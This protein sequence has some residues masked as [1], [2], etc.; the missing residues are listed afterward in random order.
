MHT[1]HL[2]SVR[3]GVVGTA[4]LIAV[5]LAS[6]IILALLALNIVDPDSTTAT[7]ASI[8]AIAIGFYAGGMFAG[9]RARAAPILHGIVI[10]LVS[11]IV[12]FLLNA[13]AAFLAPD[14]GWSALTPNLAVA[15]V[16]MQMAA[17]VLGARMGYRQTTKGAA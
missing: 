15:L 3:P 1:E 4:W 17:A 11:L 13:I 12:W 5:G 16:L 6:L 2:Q 10:G 9:L 8:A 14:F 7:R